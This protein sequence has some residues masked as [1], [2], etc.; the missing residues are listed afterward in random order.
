M[1]RTKPC[2]LPI[3]FLAIFAA[4]PFLA[5]SQNTD[6]NPLGREI[7]T[8]WLEKQ[9]RVTVEWYELTQADYRAL[10]K[11][12]E[13]ENPK[14]PIPA[15]DRPL[16]NRLDA[17]IDEDKAILL[18][19]T[20]VIAR[21]GQR[22]L[23]ESISETIYPTE[24]DPPQSVSNRTNGDNNKATVEASAPGSKLPL[25]AAFETRNVG[26]TLEV[27]PVLGPDAVTIDLNLSPEIV[28]YTGHTNWGTYLDGEAKVDVRMPQFYTLKLTTQVTLQSGDYIY[29]GVKTPPD[30]DTGKADPSRKVMMFVRGD[31]LFVGLPA[32]RTKRIQAGDKKEAK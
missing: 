8:E 26:T 28:F 4:T 1:N 7:P 12:M 25:A 6:F 15:D 9:I 14:K 16:R 32:E 29:L 3:L 27:D 18:E 19:T 13:P 17:M 5:W 11:E 31:V 30:P 22:A 24:F 10:M 23:V 20:S 21:S 2:R